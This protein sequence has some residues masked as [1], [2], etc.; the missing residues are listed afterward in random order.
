[1]METFQ[2]VLYI[3]YVLVEQDVAGQ[4][5]TVLEVTRLGLTDLDSLIFVQQEVIPD[6]MTVEDGGVILVVRLVLDAP[7]F[8]EQIMELE[9]QH[10]GEEDQCIVQ[11]LCIKLRLTQEGH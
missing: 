6:K 4:V 3:V 2:K 10:L 9:E 7:K 1:M 11:V 8:S 5:V